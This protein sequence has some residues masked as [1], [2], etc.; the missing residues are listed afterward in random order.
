[1]KSR[2]RFLAALKGET[3]DRPPVWLMRQAGRYLPDYRAVRKEHSFWDVCKSPELS[4]RVA[5][6][7]MNRFKLDAAIVFSDILTIPDALGLDVTFGP[8]EG[9][10]IGKTLKTAADLAAWKTDGVMQ[11]L[12][13]MPEAVR[14]L[15]EALKDRAGIFGFAGAPF[16]LFSYITEGSG[17]DDFIPARVMLHKEPALAQKALATLAD[18]TAEYLAAQ[19]KA[20]ADAVQ[21]FDTWGGLLSGEEY[22]KF[23]VPAIRRITEPLAKLGVPVLIYARGGQHLLPVLGETGAQGFSLDWRVDWKDARARYPKH[24]LQGNVDPLILLAGAEATREATRNLLR[25]M[26]AT[27]G[28]KLSIFNLGHGIHKDTPPETVEALVDEVVRDG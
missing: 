15:R 27:S 4:T 3:V 28:S 22:A 19:H 24:I 10:R 16:T 14:H 18:V 25:T 9:P 26:R 2:E 13:F 11:R 17:S 23:C 20:G 6:E 5:L 21:I 1:M 7:P 8:G 12:A